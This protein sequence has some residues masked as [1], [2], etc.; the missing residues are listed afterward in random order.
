MKNVLILCFLALGAMAQSGKLT[1]KDDK[2]Y[3]IEIERFE[4][5]RLKYRISPDTSLKNVP[6]DFVKLVVMDDSVKQ[7]EA[8]SVNALWVEKIVSTKNYNLSKQL[9][10]ANK[11]TI[12]KQIEN[13]KY[14]TENSPGYQLQKASGIAIGG[15]VVTMLGLGITLIGSSMTIVDPEEYLKMNDA[16]V[17]SHNKTQKAVYIV[18]GSISLLGSIIS[19]S[20]WSNVKKAGLILDSKGIGVQKKF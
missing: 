7:L 20:A 10:Q 9:V 17:L 16:E 12:M 2:S 4:K 6:I 5:L 19:L 8:I 11:T 1:T 3:D 14:N 18:G 13:Q 15:G